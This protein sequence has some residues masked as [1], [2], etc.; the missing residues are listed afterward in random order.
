MTLK[1]VLDRVATPKDNCYDCIEATL[2][3][4]YGARATHR[5]TF[6]HAT[7]TGK[8]W[9]DHMGIDDCWEK[10]SEKRLMEFY[11]KGIWFLH[12]EAA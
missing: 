5:F 9:F 12:E 6:S 10:V 7:K 4:G 8:R 2:V 1:E 3:L 11:G